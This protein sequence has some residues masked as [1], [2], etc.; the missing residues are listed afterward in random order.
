MG[1]TQSKT[2]NTTNFV[3]DIIN[4]V[5]MQSSSN[6]KTGTTVTQKLDISHINL[7]G[8]TLDINNL[9]QNVDITT[10]FQC[11]Q[12][13]TQSSDML[14]KFNT[15]LDTQLSSTL[16]G[17][18]S[19]L[20]SSAESNKINDLKNKIKSNIN[21]Q[22]L[23]SCVSKNISDQN[24]SINNI[25]I[26]CTSNPISDRKINFSNIGQ[27]VLMNNTTK[28][29]Q[30]NIQLS[31]AINDFN[32]IIQ[33]KQEAA[34]KGFDVNEFFNTLTGPI[35]YIIGAVIIIIILSSLSSMMLIS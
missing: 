30:N 6:C 5:L 20:I 11:A 27:Q 8:C 15:Q 34:N 13:I 12:D 21:L 25:T 10:N 33:D 2:T 31:A 4:N 28:C 3:N 1:A 19:S 26:D 29:I 22:Q 7:K 23:A 35:R 24:A 14:N 16:S 32:T 18:P 9:N 17:I